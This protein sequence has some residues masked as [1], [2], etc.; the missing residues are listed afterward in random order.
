M[1]YFIHN[2]ETK[3]GPFTLE[4]LKERRITSN[5]YVWREGLDSWV[6]ATQL[7]E[8]QDTIKSMDHKIG[9]APSKHQPPNDSKY[10]RINRKKLLIFCAIFLALI[11]AYWG[12]G[13]LG[14]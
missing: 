1:N 6:Q 3:E 13:Q 5:T 9:Y 2:G 10:I 8:L 7:M 4:A 12:L 11:I 14:F